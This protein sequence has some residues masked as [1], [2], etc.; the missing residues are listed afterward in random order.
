M[1]A[2]QCLHYCCHCNDLLDPYASGPG[3]TTKPCQE[4]RTYTEGLEHA[5]NLSPKES[6]AG[7]LDQPEVYIPMRTYLRR[8][9]GGDPQAW[10]GTGMLS[11][12][13]MKVFQNFKVEA[14]GNGMH[15]SLQR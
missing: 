3:D 4:G 13:V 11:F 14:R 6:D 2:S 10:R 8:K 7:V 1:W 15:L 5:S 9:G 12:K